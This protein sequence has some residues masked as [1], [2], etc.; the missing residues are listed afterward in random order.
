MS[1]NPQVTPNPTLG[2]DILRSPPDP[3]VDIVAVHGLG[4]SPEKSW[5]YEKEGSKSYHW[6][7]DDDGLAKDFPSA[8]IMLFAYSSAYA[9]RFKM[10][11]YMVNLAAEL[12]EALNLRREEQKCA[13]RPVVMLGHSMGGLVIAKALCLAESERLHYPDMYE[14]ITGCLFFGTPFNGAPV[15]EVAEHWAKMQVKE[16]TGK[17]VDS[18]LLTLLKPGNESLRELKRGFVHSVGKLSQK[19][20]VHCF[21]EELNT[22]WT[23]I[24]QKLTSENFPEEMLDKLRSKESAEFV[25]RDSASLDSSMETGLY[26]AHRDLVK[27]ESFKDPQYQRV[28]GPLKRMIQ[29]APRVARG[30]FNCTRETAIDSQTWRRVIEKLAGSDMQKVY[31]N[32]SRRLTSRSWLLDDPLWKEWSSPSEKM[33][34]CFLYIYGPKGKGK[35][36]ASV[37]SIQ[38]IKATIRKAEDDDCDSVHRPDLL[39]YYFCNQTPDRSTA[40]DLLKSLLQQLCQ[41]QA[42]LATYAKHFLK[43]SNNDSTHTVHQS[44]EHLWQ[45]LRDMLTDGTIGTI[46]FVINNLHEL[47]DPDTNES[48]KRLLAFIGA[49]IQRLTPEKGKRASTRWLFTSRERKSIQ[50]HLKPHHTV[51]RIDLEDKKYG[52]SLRSELKQHAHVQVDELQKEKGYTKAISYFAESVIGTRAEDTKWIDVAVVRLAALPPGTKDGYIRRML[53]RAPQD[54]NTLLNDA[55]S[56]IL[57]PDVDDIDSIKELLRALILAYRD[58]TEIELLVLIGSSPYDEEHRHQLQHMVEKCSPL[59]VQVRHGRET[60]IGFVNIDVKNHLLNNSDKLLDLSKDEHDLQHGF[61]ALRCFDHV[62]ERLSCSPEGLMSNNRPATPKSQYQESQEVQPTETAGSV[63]METSEAEN[64]Q[65]DS[66][67]SPFDSDTA[68]TEEQGEFLALPYATSF[69]LEHAGQATTDVTRRLSR[70][71]AFWEAG[72]SVMIRWLN[73]YERLTKAFTSRDIS[74]KDLNALHVAATL[75]YPLLVESLLEA[76]HKEEITK[77]DSLRNQPLHLAASFGKTEIIDQLLDAGAEVDESGP[78]RRN[79]T[80]LAMAAYSGSVRA[81]S[82]LIARGANKDACSANIG[83]VVN[84][85]IFSGNSAAVTELIKLGA[86]LSFE[87]WTGETTD[88]SESSDENHTTSEEPSWMPPLALAALISDISMFNAILEAAADNLTPNEH[89]KAL[90]MASHSGRIEIVEKLLG[91]EHESHIFKASLEV[92]TNEQNW[93]VVRLILKTSTGLDC[94]I[95]F[96]AASKDKEDLQDVL[97]LCWEHADGSIGQEILDDCLYI[98]TDLEKKETVEQLIKF[99]AS[100]N[101]LGSE[102]GN[103]LT[104]SAYDGTVSIA[105]ILLGH[106]ADVN[107]PE[108]YALQAAATQGH[109]PMVKLLVKHGADVNLASERHVPCTALQAACDYGN[110]DIVCF[111][112]EKGAN[113]DIGGGEND[114]PIFSAIFQGNV[115]LL[116]RLLQCES[117]DLEVSGGPQNK[118]PIHYAALHLPVAAFDK[119]I[120][121]G[122]PVDIIDAE[123]STALMEAAMV[124]DSEVVKSLLEHGA[125]VLIENSF[126]QTA[127]D[128]AAQLGETE[129]V[130]HL[131]ARAGAILRR[132][133]RAADEGDESA[134]ELINA[135]KESRS[136]DMSRAPP[137]TFDTVEEWSNFH[138]RGHARDGNED[139][140]SATGDGVENGAEDGPEDVVEDSAEDGVNEDAEAVAEDASGEGSGVEN[141]NYVQ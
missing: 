113:P 116:E 34:D 83:P 31:T 5:L 56:S 55:W 115:D 37:A 76:G 62:L 15:A 128:I 140:A 72:S 135:E 77:Y 60:T 3:T 133:K 25:S 96:R 114:R 32:L 30:R 141:R 27:F 94:E 6:L 71:T 69:W 26:R 70:E 43:D 35:T 13:R 1:A 136:D 28:R 40:E 117:L 54:F 120:K 111:L 138:S 130:H 16:N 75:G 20:E 123:G 84:A 44:V 49:D 139:D 67:S 107:A 95:P 132:L 50:K 99:G 82:K 126:G 21:F 127:L 89:S 45:C 29:S 73:E 121:H 90:I 48:T 39:A 17:A 41:Q 14:S 47:P 51:H 58:P 65:R 88:Q 18:Q 23:G 8:R 92:A 102:F 101:A 46:F 134:R 12:L 19:V 22:N 109:L 124:G 53:E 122:A 81:M 104:A 129:C 93:D 7:K 64:I 108:G 24:I 66:S 119:I 68:R 112:L 36:N 11:Q 61:L 131:A 87:G 78:E 97:E 9:K 85:A 57:R 137:K 52:K 86:R 63:I 125:D 33:S 118:T 2:L 106:E 74:A 100:C 110:L 59:L 105:E 38:S 91:Y 10:K 98:A 80:P 42:V 79:A 4:A 103:A